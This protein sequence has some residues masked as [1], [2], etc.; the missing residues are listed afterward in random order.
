MI[1]IRDVPF[2]INICS[3]EL[4]VVISTIVMVL[5][6]PEVARRMPVPMEAH[7]EM[8]C[9]FPV[10]GFITSLSGHSMV[11]HLSQCLVHF[12]VSVATL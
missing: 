1:A 11:T 4:Q 6:P 9:A 12:N 10:K 3:F 8:E 5:S 2:C 7:V